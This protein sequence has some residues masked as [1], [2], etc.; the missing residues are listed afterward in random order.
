[1]LHPTSKASPT[2]SPAFVFPRDLD[3]RMVEAVALLSHF[4][5][6]DEY[7]TAEVVEVFEAQFA[8]VPDWNESYQS[9]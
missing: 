2:A 8:G 5:S 4:A 9:N 7:T 1:M 6:T 3:H